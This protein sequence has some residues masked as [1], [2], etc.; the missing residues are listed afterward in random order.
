MRI[1]IHLFFSALLL[2][3]CKSGVFSSSTVDANVA[4][5]KHT[6]LDKWI[7]DSITLPYNIEVV[8]RWDGL[9]KQPG[10]YTY[11]PNTDKVKPILQTLRHCWLGLYDLDKVGKKGFMLGKAPLRLYIYGGKNQSED[12]M[13]FPYN[14]VVP[15]DEMHI[16]NANDFDWTKHADV[17]NLLRSVHHQ[18]AKRL[19]QQFAYDRDR[20]VKMS[21]GDYI[22]STRD[23]VPLMNNLRKKDDKKTPTWTEAQRDSVVFSMEE[24][25]NRLG[26]F[27][28]H[29]RIASEEDFCET[30]A[31]MLTNPLADIQ[32]A[33]DKAGVP[34]PPAI[35]GD[36]ESIEKERQIAEKAKRLLN[37]KMQFVEDYFSN[38]F[39]I[40]LRRAQLFSVIRMRAFVN[41][42]KT[43][44]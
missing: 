38:T 20:F 12:G 42:Q 27:T 37:S 24:T 7:R 17:F 3:A 18:F 36:P 5:R 11:P 40:S 43:A 10:T 22:S 14:A 9:H 31:A 1:Y 6:P 19:V 41:A 21:E 13:I 15:P 30:V 28:L 26:F 25:S 35:P 34:L 4:L 32:N 16:Y 29:A 8:Y 33:V 23:I 44:G 2:A 39:H